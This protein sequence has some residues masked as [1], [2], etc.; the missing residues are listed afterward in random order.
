M[1]MEPAEIVAMFRSQAGVVVDG[2]VPAFTGLYPFYDGIGAWELTFTR[3]R[4]L[5]WDGN[6]VQLWARW[7]GPLPTKR[8]VSAP[9]D[10][11]R[12]A[13][14]AKAGTGRADKYDR[15]V[16]A[17]TTVWVDKRFRE[18]LLTEVIHPAGGHRN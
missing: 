15:Y 6:T 10:A 2:A 1:T 5:A 4:F 16:L 11:L 9:H 14:P 18:L 17:R 3:R 13:A 8:K 12:M 7:G